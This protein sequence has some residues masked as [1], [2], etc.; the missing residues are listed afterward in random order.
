[1]SLKK[2][3]ITFNNK[4]KKICWKIIF[5]PLLFL[6]FQLFSKRQKNTHP[7]RTIT[8][9]LDPAG[10][11]KHT[12]R[13]LQ[14]SFERGITLQCTEHLK[15]ELEEQFPNIRVVLTRFPGE[16]VEPLQ[17][18]NFANRLNVD[19]YLSIHFYQ[20]QGTK[21]ELTLYS[22]SYGDDFVTQK[23]DDISLIPFD[24]AHLTNKEK[25]QKF[26]IQMKDILHRDTY[27]KWFT[28]KGLFKLPFKPLIG[29]KAPALAI[30]IS[31]K[32]DNDWINYIKPLTDSL[33]PIINDLIKTF[34]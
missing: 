27:T 34:P 15:H 24:N 19:F 7:L 25:T 20:E 31:L 28:V 23:I 2:G 33:K 8:I 3:Y 30:E 5:L 6:S 4:Q 1:M 22:F 14:G 29:I 18:A 10:D 11:A 13:T 9:M 21:P 17:N 32:Q 26:A 16:A 12:G